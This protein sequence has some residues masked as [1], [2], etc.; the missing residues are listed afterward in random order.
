MWSTPPDASTIYLFIFSF[1]KILTCFA[2]SKYYNFFFTG[3]SSKCVISTCNKTTH[4]GHAVQLRSRTMHFT[5]ATGLNRKRKHIVN[6]CWML[7]RWFSNDLYANDELSALRVLECR[8]PG[9]RFT[10]LNIIVYNNIMYPFLFSKWIFN[11]L[12]RAE[13][14]LEMKWLIFHVGQIDLRNSV[15]AIESRRNF[16]RN[17]AIISHMFSLCIRVDFVI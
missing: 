5:S 7:R 4:I 14:D 10:F 17:I 11:L 2:F 12:S 15:L 13:P 16:Q 6:R 3:K 9:Y 1:L 8:Y